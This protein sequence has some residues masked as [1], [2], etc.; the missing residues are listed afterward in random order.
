MEAGLPV[1]TS[2]FKKWD[3]FVIGNNIGVTIDPQNIT[4]LSN[5]IIQIL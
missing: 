4:Q 5:A 1:I 3:N 2:N